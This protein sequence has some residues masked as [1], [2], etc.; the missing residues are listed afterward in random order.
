MP[1]I[2]WKKPSSHIM[3]AAKAI[4]PTQPVF[5]CD[6]AMGD[7]LSWAGERVS[8]MRAPSAALHG[9]EDGPARAAAHA[10]L[11]PDDLG[12]DDLGPDALGP[13]HLGPDDLLP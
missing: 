4:R 2:A 11:G 12:P 8:D 13:D 6:G 5:F 1:A 3:A 10:S 7:V 9:R